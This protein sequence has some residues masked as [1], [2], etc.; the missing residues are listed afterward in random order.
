MIKTTTIVLAAAAACSMCGCK[1]PTAPPPVA[2]ATGEAIHADGPVILDESLQRETMLGLGHVVKVV[3]EDHGH[4]RAPTGTHQVW[5]RLRNVTDYDQNLQGRVHFL[6]ENGEEVEEPSPWG[7][8]F[9]PARS[10]ETYRAAST[11]R[12]EV[13]RFYVELRAGR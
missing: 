11:Q 9:L 6:G 7:R 3:L 8:I 10:I 13:K 2:K 4:S 1:S 5:V 12:D